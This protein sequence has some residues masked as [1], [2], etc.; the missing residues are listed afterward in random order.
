MQTA[1]LCLTPLASISI[2]V[3]AIPIVATVMGLGLAMLS[4]FLNYR[5]RRELYT[6]HHQERMAAIDKGI[7]VPPLP[8]G[9]LSEE[10]RPVSPRRIL[11][12]GLIWALGGSCLTAALYVND[13]IDAA[14]FGLITVAVGVAYLVY[15]FAVGRREA[16]L[17]DQER[18]ARL[19]ATNPS[20][21]V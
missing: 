10:P 21:G 16:E 2:E 8:E 7:D 4:V 3:I 5:R 19:S 13:G 17:A 18:K 1:A 6:L 11:L 9:L 20:R 12:K 14:L 15:F